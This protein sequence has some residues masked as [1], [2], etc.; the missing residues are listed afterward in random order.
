MA[1][2]RPFGIT[3]LA[4]LALVAALIAGI[5][6]LQLLHLWPVGGWFG[7]TRFFTFDLW[8]A[9]L[10]GIMFLIYLWVFQM[11]WTVN[12][13]GWLFVVIIAVF[14]LIMAVL[15]ILGE[16]SWEA[17]W[18]ALLINGIILIYC[19]MPGVKQ[20]FGLPTST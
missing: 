8:G 20:A 16:S 10:W 6:T 18:P 3:L 9:I 11:L 2:S 7:D 14:N 15:S 5:Y 1:R 4:I 19:L 17:M 13:Q 12:P